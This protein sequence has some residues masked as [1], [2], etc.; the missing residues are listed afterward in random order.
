M[1]EY[2]FSDMINEFINRFDNY[3]YI[4]TKEIENLI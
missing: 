4:V 1:K 2:G 3:E